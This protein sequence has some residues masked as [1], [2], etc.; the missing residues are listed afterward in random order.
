MSRSRYSKLTSLFG[1]VIPGHSA[2]LRGPPLRR[3]TQRE[4][5]ENLDSPA[6]GPNGI[7]TRVWSRSRFRQE[8]RIVLSDKSP[9]TVTQLKHAV[10]GCLQH[11]SKVRSFIAGARITCGQTSRSSVKV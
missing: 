10:S 4:T 9:S 2:V 5:P 1:G 3:E 11:H 8:S 6:G 7:R